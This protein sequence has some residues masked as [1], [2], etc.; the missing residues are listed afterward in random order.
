[1]PPVLDERAG[2]LAEAE[3]IESEAAVEWGV[4]DDDGQVIMCP[5]E[6]AAGDYQSAHGGLVVSRITYTVRDLPV[7]PCPDGRP[8]PGNPDHWPAATS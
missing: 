7:R 4:I 2:L 3:Q 6:R 8:V 1:M 5:D